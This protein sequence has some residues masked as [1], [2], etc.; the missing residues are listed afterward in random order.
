MS[1]RGVDEAPTREYAV[2]IQAMCQ[3]DCQRVI[4]D[5]RE[6]VFSEVTDEKLMKR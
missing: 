3:I 6:R 4:G 2:D 5:L 1:E